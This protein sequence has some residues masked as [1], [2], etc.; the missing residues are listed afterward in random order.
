MERDA[1]PTMLFN[2]L[3]EHIAEICGMKEPAAQGTFTA[4]LRP[5]ETKSSTHYDEVRVSVDFGEGRL[6]LKIEPYVS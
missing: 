4:S 5:T 2:P 3:K 6:R 1:L